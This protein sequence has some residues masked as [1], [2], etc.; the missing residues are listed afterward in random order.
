M[1]KFEKYDRVELNQDLKDY[2]LL[3]GETGMIMGYDE[4]EG[5]YAVHFDF[6]DESEELLHDCKGMVNGMKGLFLDGSVLRKQ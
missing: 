6:D 4:E 1:I 3:E 2:D 5:L